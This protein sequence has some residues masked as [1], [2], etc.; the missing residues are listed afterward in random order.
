M[1]KF[2]GEINGVTYTDQREFEKS[3]TEF[4]RNAG[5]TDPVTVSFSIE[6]IEEDEDNQLNEEPERQQQTETNIRKALREHS[7]KDDNDTDNRRLCNTADAIRSVVDETSTRLESFIDAEVG[8]QDYR[9]VH[10]LEN[11][12]DS[13]L[14]KIDWLVQSL[15]AHLRELLC[16]S[17][18]GATEEMVDKINSGLVDSRYE[19]AK[20][21]ELISDEIQE[22]N[23][24]IDSIDDQIRNL[25][26]DREKIYGEINKR[27]EEYNLNETKINSIC[28]AKK[29][30]DGLLNAFSM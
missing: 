27:Q 7:D 20:E 25:D 2:R 24:E 26:G 17:I 11:I 28:I 13:A 8:E 9:S 30:F 15:P 16:N 3:Y 10:E 23:E 18:Y 1:R 5:P 12:V 14:M 22:F 21:Q 4:C 29:F 19:I 6:E